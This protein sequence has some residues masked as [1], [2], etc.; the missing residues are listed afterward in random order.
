MDVLM[1]GN[2]EVWVV[3]I[4]WGDLDDVEILVSPTEAEA[5]AAARRAV[6]ETMA[7]TTPEYNPDG[8]REFVLEPAAILMGSD[9]APDG[10]LV[11]DLDDATWLAALHEIA[12]VPW[13]TIERHEVSINPVSR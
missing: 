11:V 4:E 3:V 12:T 7:A 1:F 10:T 13:V 5:Q 2:T 9:H 8:C 6:I